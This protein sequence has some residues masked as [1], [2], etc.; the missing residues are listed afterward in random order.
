MSNQYIYFDYN[1]ASIPSL[2]VIAAVNTIINQP[3]NASA[4]HSLGQKSFGLIEDA[5]DIILRK[6]ANKNYNIVFTAT[7]S[8]AN[9]MAIKTINGIELFICSAAEHKSVIMAMHENKEIIP[10]DN[11]SL[12][13]ENALFEMIEKNVN[14]KIFLSLI[15]ANNETG[16]INDL[17]RIINKIR[18]LHNNII[19][20]SD[21]ACMIDKKPLNLVDLGVDM[22]TIIAYKFGG[23]L[24]AAALIYKKNIDLKPMIEGGMQESNLR[25]GTENALAIHAMKVAI[26]RI[27]YNQEVQIL[28]DYFESELKKITNQ[29]V[30]IF[31]ETVN[32]INNTSYFAIEGLT[33]KTAIIALNGENIYVSAGSACSA[34]LDEASHVLIA[35]NI[36]ENLRKCAIRVSFGIS[37]KKEEV[38]ILL[39]R[40]SKLYRK[41]RI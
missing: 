32:R 25:A 14:K 15:Y 13:N 10:V 11:N 2:E 24:G 35:M 21:I 27:N 16:A 1:S 40:L 31:S 17:P 9:N 38:E 39:D 29:E 33:S 23:I 3:L 7:G 5:R 36:P 12:I 20:H 26:D 22:A 18:T 4:I 6:I 41:F 19:I 37:N 34:G 30:V 28:R 8:E